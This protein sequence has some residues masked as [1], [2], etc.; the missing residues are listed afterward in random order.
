MNK[1]LGYIIR[2][3]SF[4]IAF[5]VGKYYPGILLQL[6]VA[7]LLYWLGKKIIK[8]TIV[9]NVSKDDSLKK[10]VYILSGLGLLGLWIPIV[11]FVFALPAFLI[12][13]EIIT[14]KYNSRKKVVTFATLI[15]ILCM[16]NAALGTV[17]YQGGL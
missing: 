14:P 13:T 10:K 4:L 11:G 9:T 12:A 7:Y 1:I 6:I 5:V 16:L 3:G 17:L 2:W 15:L 8:K